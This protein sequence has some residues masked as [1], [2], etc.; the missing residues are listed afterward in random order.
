MM[1]LRL[2]LLLGI[3]FFH[4]YHLGVRPPHHDEAVN[5]WFVDGLFQ[6]GF[7][8]YDPQNYHGP[9]HFY[10]LAFFEMLFGRSI[11]VLRLPTVLFGALITFT[12]FLFKK[13]LTNRGAWIAAFFLA[14]SPAMVF[15]ARYAI[16]EMG[17]MLACILFFYFW[18]ETK[19]ETFTLKN[20]IG[21]GLTLAF[22]AC[23][24]ENFILLVVCMFLGEGALF[25]IQKFFP[26]SL[27]LKKKNS[28]NIENLAQHPDWRSKQTLKGVM[29]VLI[30][31]GVLTAAIFSALGRDWV[32]IK[33]FFQAFI[34]WSETGSKGNGHEKPIYYWVNILF[35]LEWFALL[36]LL[37][38][39][40]VFK[41]IRSEIRL[42]IIV[43]V[44]LFCAY[45]LVNYKTPWCLL[46]FYWGFIFFAAF[47]VSTGME[48]KKF[49]IPLL[50]FLIL[51]FTFSAYQAYEVSYV[52]VDSDHHPY[53]YGQ[54]YRD[55]M[56][57]LQE[58][59]QQLKEN[60]ALKEKIHLQVI[61]QFTWPLPWILGEIKLS[62]YYGEQNVPEVLDAEY[63]IMD[64]SFEDKF[65]PRL[66]GEYERTEARARQW[67]S[68][69]VFF[70]K[71]K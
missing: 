3:L 48:I 19:R 45:S 8:H 27:P 47:W 35:E 9:L 16:H 62:G 12:P 36:G 31:F 17:F 65:A 15:Y 51:G 57:P 26:D 34:L 41:K 30:V 23:Y 13:I 56:P 67:A 52:D 59:T 71:K 50:V 49:K 33:N 39:P 44:G 14:V 4:A 21:L 68:N 20:T 29:G 28:K 61:S 10:I 11:E 46:S 1:N 18:L 32:G 5:G 2:I 43:T 38:A 58:I 7:Y 63:V 24:K 70:K 54:T 60:P 66:K 37:C 69:L 25:C 42:L 6:S 40:L 55:L 22:M 53:I 64:K